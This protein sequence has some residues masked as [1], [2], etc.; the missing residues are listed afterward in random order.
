MSDTPEQNIQADDAQ[1]QAG[2]NDANAELLNKIALLEA[3]NKK[4]LT[5]KKNAS[6]SVEDLQ[7]QISDLQNNQQKAKQS[8]LAE[9]GEFKTLWQDATTTV[10][11]LQDEIAQLKTQ[12]E[13]K[14]VAFQQQQ[15]KASAL[16]AISQAG[17]HNPDQAFSLLKDNL[18]LK[19]GVP[20]ALAGGVEVPL[21]QHLESLR[22]PGSGW[23]HH[24]AGSGARGMS[25]AGSSSSTAGQ[26]SWGSM[27]LTERITLEMEQPDRA[28]QLKAAG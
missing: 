7:R 25:A 11:S 28:A 9:A 3:N 2:G 12:L 17:I 18:R 19:D 6:A 4:L 10:S 14:D 23:E 8:Q 13:E 26:K 22:Q 1:A 5:E 20:I 24:F 21:Q 16:N 15:I 27:S